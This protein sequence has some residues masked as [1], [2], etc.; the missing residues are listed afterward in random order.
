M[1]HIN[2][3]ALHAQPVAQLLSTLLAHA[4]NNH[5]IRVQAVNERCHSLILVFIGCFRQTCLIFSTVA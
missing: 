2:V 5:Q 4:E 3:I 1:Q